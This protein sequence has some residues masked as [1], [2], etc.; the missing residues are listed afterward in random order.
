MELCNKGYNSNL[1]NLLVKHQNSSVYWHR[2]RL[3]SGVSLICFYGII[4]EIF[5]AELHGWLTVDERA[6]ARLYPWNHEVSI[7]L[8]RRRESE[9]IYRKNCTCRGCFARE[10]AWS[11]RPQPAPLSFSGYSRSITPETIFNDISLWPFSPMSH[12]PGAKTWT[13]ILNT[14]YTFC[15]NRVWAIGDES[16]FLKSLKRAEKYIKSPKNGSN[17]G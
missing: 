15:S 1:K 5:L 4:L 11:W 2:W 7:F 14:W 12:P 8:G 17:R 6:F 3:L 9:V 10:A 16:K 13:V